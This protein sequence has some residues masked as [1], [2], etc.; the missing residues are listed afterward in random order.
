MRGLRCPA[1]SGQ[2]QRTLLSSRVTQSGTTGSRPPHL[3]GMRCQVILG[4]ARM[5]TYT[6]AVPL[7]RVEKT[8]GM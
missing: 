8:T 2:P 5:P 1:D 3:K 4:V 6:Q 7:D